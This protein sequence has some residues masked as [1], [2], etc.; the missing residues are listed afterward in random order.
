VDEGQDPGHHD[1]SHSP[2][3]PSAVG[4]YEACRKQIEAEDSLIGVRVGW[5]VTAEAFLFAAYG[6]VLAIQSKFVPPTTHPYDHRLFDVVPLVG[7]TVAVL[8][9]IGI[10]A[11]MHRLRVL[12]ECSPL[13][14]PPDYPSL[15]AED[16]VVM[17]GHAAAALV[18]PIVIESW[19]FVWQGGTW[20]A[21]SCPMIV[22]AGFLGYAEHLEL[23]I[24]AL[25]R[26]E[27]RS[28]RLRH[29]VALKRQIRELLGPHSEK[30]PESVS[31]GTVPIL[32]AT[33]MT[34]PDV[35]HQVL[36]NALVGSED[37]GPAY[38]APAQNNGIP[39]P[40]DDTT[41][42]RRTRR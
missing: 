10:G 19:I 5:L 25:N 7:I 18:A 22:V 35:A 32:P 11:A 31:A 37:D 28:P 16:L 21:L 23:T 6:A 17:F 30:T 14:L 12:S 39:A 1:Q 24:D 20:V 13:D 29:Y 38:P 2:C 15:W 34:D 27:P 36:I 8:I 26:R 9:G 33:S 3:G 42:R 40:D 4:A 41:T